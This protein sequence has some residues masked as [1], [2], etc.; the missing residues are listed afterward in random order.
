MLDP[1]IYRAAI[2]P[3]LFAL[4]L[5]AFSLQDRPRPVRTTLAPDAFDGERAYG[6]AQG[7]L[8]LAARYPS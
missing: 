1:R 5:V 7:L 6:R 3:V 2:L 8:G 4:V